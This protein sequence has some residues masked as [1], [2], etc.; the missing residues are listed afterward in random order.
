MTNEQQARALALELIDDEWWIV[1]HVP[2]MGPYAFK[3]DAADDMAGVKRFY[4]D[5]CI[6]DPMDDLLDDILR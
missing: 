5:F 4:R 2:T 6:K 3:K 1:N